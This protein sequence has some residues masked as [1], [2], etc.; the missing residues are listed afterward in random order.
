[1]NRLITAATRRGARVDSIESCGLDDLYAQSQRCQGA[2]QPRRSGDRPCGGRPSSEGDPGRSCKGSSHHLRRSAR[3]D[4]A[5]HPARRLRHSALGPRTHCGGAST[6]RL[7]SRS[8]DRALR[9]ARNPLRR[10]TTEDKKVTVG[11]GFK[12]VWPLKSRDDRLTSRRS[13]TVVGRP[14]GRITHVERALVRTL[15]GLPARCTYARQVFYKTSAGTTAIGE[16][17]A[18]NL[19]QNRT[20]ATRTKTSLGRS[21]SVCAIALTHAEGWC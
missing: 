16:S 14:P 20:S 9:K 6:S 12:S 4:R 18:L 8:F 10:V 2:L 13:L 21:Y 15:T 1:M 11:P 17:P 7:N 19:H 5:Q 3:G